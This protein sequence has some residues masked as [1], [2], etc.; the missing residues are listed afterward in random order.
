MRGRTPETGLQKHLLPKR[1]HDYLHVAVDDATR[2]AFVEVFSDDRA[3]SCAAFLYNAH[4]FF[5]GLGVTVERV[6][7][8][9]A[10]SYRKKLFPEAAARLGIKLRRTRP[11]RPQ[12]N[13]KA[14][15][16]IRTA[17]HGWAFAELYPSNDER[18]L[19]L[20][21]WIDFYNRQRPH[22]AHRGLS[23]MRVL[24]NKVLED[25]T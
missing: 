2:V 16:F 5:A 22:R 8:D 24:A 23:P 13:G 11:Y 1:G 10:F 4:G 18:L 19:A 7:T 17:L 6:L 14:E 20:P 15:R 3:A 25:Y 9:N 12:T 21:V